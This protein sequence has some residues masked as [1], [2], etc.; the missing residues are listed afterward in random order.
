MSN[1]N[2]AARNKATKI[3][4]DSRNSLYFHLFRV[5]DYRRTHNGMEYPGTVWLVAFL[6]AVGDHSTCD[7]CG[8]I[9]FGFFSLGDPR[10]AFVFL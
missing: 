2:D 1:L 6:I 7:Y 3:Y 4:H 5:M 9:L 8:V 10:K